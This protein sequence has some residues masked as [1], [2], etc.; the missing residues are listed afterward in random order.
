MSLNAHDRQALALIEEALAGGDPQFASK[1]SAFS[2]LAEDGAMPERERIHQDGRRMIVRAIRGLRL[3][4]PG[5]SKLLR[6]VT[7]AMWVAISVALISAAVA[8]SR[9]GGKPGCAQWQ[10]TTCVRSV[11]PSTPSTVP[12]IRSRR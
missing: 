12:R 10:A 8:M 3:G 5:T 6:W 4:Q 1:L 7:V 11:A 2:R 9:A